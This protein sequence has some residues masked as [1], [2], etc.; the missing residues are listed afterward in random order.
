MAIRVYRS[1]EN[2]VTEKATQPHSR[3]GCFF[4]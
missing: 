1:W 4:C 3:A 2:T